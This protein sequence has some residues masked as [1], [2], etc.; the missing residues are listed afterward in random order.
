MAV[1]Q[2]ILIEDQP[3]NRELV[4][5]LLEAEGY[6][7]LGASTAEEGMALARDGRSRL[8]LMDI[9]LPGIDGLTAACL[10]KADPRTRHIP[11]LIVTA[12]AMKRE[13]EVARA[14]GCAG[15]VTKPINTRE[16]RRTVAG[17]V[18]PS[19]VLQAA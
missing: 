16:F 18:R 13:E 1:E 11:I 10:L 19:E 14:A 2:I 8:I 6:R 15:Y 17:L 3:L 4:T 12:H 5:D 7:V 9:A